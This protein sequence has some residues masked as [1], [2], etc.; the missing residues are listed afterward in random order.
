VACKFAE[1]ADCTTPVASEVVVTL[2]AG[3]VM[4]MLRFA[5]DACVVG[6]SESVTVTPKLIGPVTLPVGV[7]VIWPVEAFNARPA[8]KLPVVTAHV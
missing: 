3:A 8:G 6:V 7:P 1:Y 5:V 2:S 4:V